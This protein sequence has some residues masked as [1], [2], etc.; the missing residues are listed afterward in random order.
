V[1]YRLHRAA[2]G[3]RLAPDQTR[4]KVTYEQFALDRSQLTGGPGLAAGTQAFALRFVQR[5]AFLTDY[6]AVLTNEEFVNRLFTTA[7]LNGPH[8]DTAR[9]AEIEAMNSQSKYLEKG[10][11]NSAFSSKV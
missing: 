6:P 5:P 4:A 7:S 2:F 9:H 11:I 8:F 10:G 3:T 1:V